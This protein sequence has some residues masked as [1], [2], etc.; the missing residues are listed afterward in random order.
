MRCD[1]M[2][3]WLQ[4]SQENNDNKKNGALDCSTAPLKV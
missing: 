4:E 1:A 2:A 3:L